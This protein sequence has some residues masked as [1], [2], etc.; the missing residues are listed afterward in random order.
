MTSIL[1]DPYT[2]VSCYIIDE[3]E[4]CEETKSEN[5]TLEEKQKTPDYE[6]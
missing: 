4:S 3:V 1:Q 2:E 6:V 5:Q